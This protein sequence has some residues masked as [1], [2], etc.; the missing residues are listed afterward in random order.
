MDTGQAVGAGRAMG[1]YIFRL[2][3]YSLPL[4]TN[5]VFHKM[6]KKMWCSQRMVVPTLSKVC[7]RFVQ[8][9]SRFTQSGQGVDSGL[10]VGH[11]PF[12]RLDNVKT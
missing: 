7:L 12:L 3:D 6:L 10:A 5:K 11:G 2:C 8:G 4:V 1:T 9:L